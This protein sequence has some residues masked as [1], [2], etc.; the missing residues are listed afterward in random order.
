MFQPSV[1]TTVLSLGAFA[2]TLSAADLCGSVV[3]EKS[4]QPLAARV[5]ILGQDGAW[6]FVRSAAPGG[7]AV[8]YEKRNGINRNAVEMHTTVSNQPFA[9]DLPPGRYVV[10]V[11]RGKEYF[12]VT[13]EVT[14]AAEPVEL[15]IPL[16]RWIDMTER[17]W[18][19]GE[20]HIHR[21]PDELRNVVL[22]EDL[23]VAF[24]LSFWV[25]RAF[26]SPAA[27]VRGAADFPRDLMSVDATHVIWPR[28]TEYEIFTVGAKQHTL[29]A[30]FVLNHH[31]PLAAGVPPWGKV[32][33][34]SLAREAMIDVD[35]LDWP[36]AML[37]PQAASPE[38]Y[39]L[40]NN[41]VWRTEF[42]FRTWNCP[43]TPYLQPPYG[44]RGGGE[45]EWVHYT[46]GMYYTLLNCGLAVVPTAGT[47][48]G[49][50][51]VPA[52]F[53]R[54]YVHLPGGFTYEKWVAGLKAGRSFVTTGPMLFATVNGQDPGET[55]RADCGPVRLR[56]AGTVRSEQP[57]A[58]IEVIR[59]GR[60]ALTFMPP[61]PA[62]HRRSI[63]DR[64]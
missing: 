28:N 24:P 34:A 4:G 25:T 3:D 43:A 38:L 19:S 48:N 46:L 6:H 8:R 10:T 9:A 63:R 56:I 26:T 52:G 15:R 30:M 13:R 55:F 37:L 16:R 44:G 18:Y 51:P 5:Y 40:A 59:D 49:V 61:Q 62:D 50:H 54:V 60:P 14:V 23:N 41:H 21:T 57:L 17:G 35:K 11:E 12:A 39:E 31:E 53:S 2:A 20:T 45:R 1:L 42:A 27:E 32:A 29:G 33:H 7:S 58:F 64:L 22:A 36:F 47:A